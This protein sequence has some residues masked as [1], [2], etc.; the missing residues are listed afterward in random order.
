MTEP[1]PGK[2]KGMHMRTY[3]QVRGKYEKAYEE[4]SQE[5]LVHLERLTKGMNKGQPEDS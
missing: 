4:Y 5:I 2:P 1:F 3:V